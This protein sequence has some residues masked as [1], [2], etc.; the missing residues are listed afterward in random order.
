MKEMFRPLLRFWQGGDDLEMPLPAGRMIFGGS[1][2][3][4]HLGHMSLVSYVLQQGLAR[5][6]MLVP[7]GQSPF[8][9]TQVYAPAEHRLKMLHLAVQELPEDV[10]SRITISDSEIK[11]PGPS[12][13]VDTLRELDDGIQTALLIGADNLASF[14]RW[15]EADW[16]LSR[17]PLYVVCRHGVDEDRVM[18]MR[19]ELQGYFPVATVYLIPFEPPACSS[20]QIRR[21]LAG[22]AGFAQLKDCLPQ[23]I[24]AYI[25]H[26][27]LY[28]EDV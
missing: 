5:S 16:I 2:N 15:K 19:S 26:V 20:T 24:F 11:R 14:S 28:T 18:A 3:P 23:S 9:D 10:Q 27:G 17:V 12:Y 4:A 8:K 1:F 13:T 25:R 6:V 7:T 22:G 21:D